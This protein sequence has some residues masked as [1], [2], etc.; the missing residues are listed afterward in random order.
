MINFNLPDFEMGVAIY[1][2]VVKYQNL[3]PYIFY[4]PQ[5]KINSVFGCY[6]R[7]LWNGG[8]VLLGAQGICTVE[9]M[10]AMIDEYNNKMNIPLRFTF[11]N[12][13][14][15][16][17][18]CDDTF[19]NIIA[20]TAHN[21]KNEIL[22]VSPVLEE[23]LR[24]N[25]PNYK[26]IRSIVGSQNKPY[27][28]DPKYYMSVMQRRMNNNWDYLDKIPVEHRNKIEFLCNDPCDDNCPRI[29]SHYLEYAK[30]Q[31][32]C[33]RTKNWKCSNR[34]DHPFAYQDLKIRET[35]ISRKMIEKDYLPKGFNQFKLSGRRNLSKIIDNIVTYMIKPEYHSDMY[36]IL[37]KEYRE[38]ERNVCV[39]YFR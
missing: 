26:Y 22:V 16:E 5:D 8:G 23:Y 25:Y 10:K 9:G 24:K 2:I 19:C 14:I 36:A 1:N 33:E 31:L 17:K 4:N 32:S 37:Y 15:E 6:A 35:H 39:P 27:D 30:M 13:L 11:T 18:H 28:P 34:L 12:P 7:A 29:Y 3:Y 20:E 38:W 21:G